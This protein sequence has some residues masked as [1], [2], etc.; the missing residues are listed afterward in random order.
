MNVGC[1]AREELLGQDLP[2]GC[3]PGELSHFNRPPRTL[4]QG[5]GWARAHRLTFR[6]PWLFPD[7]GARLAGLEAIAMQLVV[8]VR[9][10]CSG[11]GRPQRDACEAS[12]S[13]SENLAT[14]H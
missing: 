6:S 3:Q 7:R 14:V 2:P 10:L 12:S 1:Q 11:L 5:V 4:G 8:V 9:M 13:D